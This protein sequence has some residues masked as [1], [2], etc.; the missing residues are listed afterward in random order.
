[1]AAPLLPAEGHTSLL[2]SA[3][4][5]PHVST[6]SLSRGG[7]PQETFLHVM[8]YLDEGK[9]VRCSHVCSNWRKAIV[10]CKA[11]WTELDG[12]KVAHFEAP[13]RGGLRT[14]TLCFDGD[15][16]LLVGE[17]QAAITLR[18][19]LREITVLDG[20]RN[21]RYL[22]LDLLPFRRY[23]DQAPAYDCVFAEFSAVNLETLKIL[24]PLD[25]FP[26]GAPFFDTPVSNLYELLAKCASSLEVLWLRSVS[27]DPPSDYLPQAPGTT[28]KDI[29]P[30]LLLPRLTDV[31][32]CGEDVPLLW[33]K[34]TYTSPSFCIDTPVL[35]K[36]SFS[37]QQR[38]EADFCY[39]IEEDRLDA[40]EAL[41]GEALSNL[42]R[43]S[44]QL[45]AVN[46]TNTNV[47]AA[48]LVAS[49]PFASSILTHLNIGG[50]PAAWTPL[51]TVS[52]TSLPS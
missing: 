1:M 52:T 23:R 34:P 20:A 9:L 51:S 39:T 11:L 49:L 15:D 26:A 13:D 2:F 33:L 36:V 40:V 17:L 6:A 12:V 21:L 24:T 7:L 28:Q 30:V 27:A 8:A 31:Q 38:F 41:S 4:F 29:P 43:N 47:E 32:L 18:Q 44:P 48:M 16:D 46:L 42:F 3:S 22:E 14:L 35:R 37:D 10:E 19:I 50:T 25:R 45:E 5:S